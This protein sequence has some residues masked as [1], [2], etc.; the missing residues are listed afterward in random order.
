MNWRL[1]PFTPL[2]SISPIPGWKAL[3][4][5]MKVDAKTNRAR[6]TLEFILRVKLGSLMNHTGEADLKLRVVAGFQRTKFPNNSV[7]FY[8]QIYFCRP[9]FTFCNCVCRLPR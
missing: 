7:L 1:R 5:I 2:R 4:S 8:R 9:E 3:L 6:T